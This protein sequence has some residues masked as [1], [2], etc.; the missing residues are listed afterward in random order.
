MNNLRVAVLVTLVAL[1]V[2]FLVGMG[3][4]ALWD[5]GWW[6]YAWWPMAL[7]I[8][9]AYA[10]AWY[11]QRKKR[12][13]PD[14]FEAAGHWTDRDRAA[15]KLI[16]ARA[17]VVKDIP[18][19][20]L[21]D[22]QA[23]FD[24]A[25]SLALELARFY[26]PKSGDP[27]G[28]VTVPEIL[29]VIELASHDL[30]ELVD[31]YLPGGH[32]LTVN[33]WR[34][35]PRVS[36]W[37]DTASKVY[38]GVAALFN[39]VQTGA[40]YLASQLGISQPWQML[41]QSLID[42]FYTA[43]LH[44]LGTYLIELYS[45]RLRVGAS[46]YREL[47]EQYAR[48]VAPVPAP[49][50]AADGE[51]GPPPAPQVTIALFGQVKAGKSSLVN[52]LLGEQKARTDVLPATDR[53]TRYELNPAHVP[54]KLS[55]LDTVGYGHE[56][57]RADDLPA[58]ERAA[59]AADVLLLVLHARNPARA[60]DVTMLQKLRSYFTDRPDLKR[61]PIIAVLTHIDLLSPA[62]EWSPPYDW[63]NPTRPKE[64]SIRDAV[65]TAHEQLGDL[66]AVLP[67]CAAVGKEYGVQEELLPEVLSRLD[68][69][70][71]V[72]LLRVLRSELE[73]G[74]VMKVFRQLVSVAAEAAKR[75]LA[76]VSPRG[77]R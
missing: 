73:H 30:G 37:Y 62:M 52:A 72:A 17:A 34:Q 63:R 18:I 42:W 77:E 61:P 32:L 24:D 53:V 20:R 28:R 70:R 68:E 25:R 27:L 13:L 9:G 66:T 1:P 50:A 44:R 43:Y 71:A 60:A 49:P 29:A 5:Y 65:A 69:A 11:W 23:Y 35:A 4:Y 76:P 64:R 40:R 10:L 6:F 7:C 47:V 59:R 31:R 21:Q 41:Q 19:E 54:T 16:E 33:H 51:S 12:L 3:S 2:L 26:H 22:P 67:V 57:P 38:W 14:K 58:T 39:P 55:I 46:R 48:P 74:Q 45:G 75:V 8:G 56:G 36:K 15:W